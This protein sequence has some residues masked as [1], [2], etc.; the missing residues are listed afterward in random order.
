MSVWNDVRLAVRMLLRD[1]SFTFTAA[2]ALALGI[3]A[4]S[5]VFTLVNGV[6]LRELPFHEP[7]R[8]MA[9]ESR[10]TGNSN[11]SYL[12]LRDLQGSVRTFSGVAGVDQASMQLADEAGAAE[13]L[14][15]AYVSANMFGLLGRQ[16]VLGRDFRDEDD[17][18]GAE[19]VALLGYQLWQRRYGGDPGIFGRSIR[20]NGVPS[21]VIGVMPEQFG[22][23]EVAELWQ[24]LATLSAS[25]RERRNIRSLGA[26][27]RLAPERKLAAGGGRARHA[28]GRP[29]APVSGHE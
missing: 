26:I 14:T 6:L 9:I 2:S 23:P 5:L 28:H 13:R 29:G 11:V 3:A 12:D 18:P 15:G 24:P 16:P 20:V 4:N 1:R 7:N 22:F 19:P 25:V 8:L 27:G 17:R 21:T 10:K